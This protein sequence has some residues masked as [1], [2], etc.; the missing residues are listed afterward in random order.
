MDE[1]LP[2][3]VLCGAESR[4]DEDGDVDCSRGACTCPLSAG[5]FTRDQWRTVNAPRDSTG[6][7]PVMALAERFVEWAMKEAD[8]TPS[9]DYATVLAEMAGDVVQHMWED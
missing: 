6:P 5:V 3:C 1:E 2:R 4:E 7:D 8:S 9:F